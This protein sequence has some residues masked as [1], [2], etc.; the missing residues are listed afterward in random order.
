MAAVEGGVGIVDCVAVQGV[1]AEGVAQ[2]DGVGGVDDG[3]RCGVA[4]AQADECDQGGEYE[5]GGL[6]HFFWG[7]IVVIVVIGDYRGLWEG[8]GQVSVGVVI[9]GSREGWRV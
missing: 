1:V 7:V 3:R 4:G 5:G 8:G 6:F 9:W 2:G